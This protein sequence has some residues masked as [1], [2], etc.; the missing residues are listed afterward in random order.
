MANPGT[1]D[2][3]L[4]AI[5]ALSTTNGG[6]ADA[7]EVVYGDEMP[8]NAFVGNGRYKACQDFT[9]NLANMK[10][11]PTFKAADSYIYF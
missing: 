11:T 5:T 6:T 8:A 4:S 9:F 1:G 10:Y 7:N 3:V 2:L